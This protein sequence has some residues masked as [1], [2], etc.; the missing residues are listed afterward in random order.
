MFV[1]T[2]ERAKELFRELI[3]DNIMV[4]AIHADRTQTQVWRMF[5][6]CFMLFNYWI[7]LP[8]HSVISFALIEYYA[9]IPLWYFN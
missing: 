3:Y 5:F 9:K 7:I 6:I 2:K 1:Q 8:K 4:D